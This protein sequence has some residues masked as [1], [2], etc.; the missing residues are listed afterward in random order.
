MLVS[1]FHGNNGMF[2]K[3]IELLSIQCIVYKYTSVITEQFTAKAHP[4]LLRGGWEGWGAKTAKARTLYVYF[5][6]QNNVLIRS[7]VCYCSCFF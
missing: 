5:V 6:C 2:E 7:V 4:V 1:L 3:K